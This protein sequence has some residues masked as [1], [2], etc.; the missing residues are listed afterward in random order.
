M[1]S[2]TTILR[3]DEAMV[4][5]GLGAIKGVG[6]SIIKIIIDARQQG[7]FKNLLDFCSR[8][9]RRVINKKSFEALICSG[10]MDDLHDL[11]SEG[12]SEMLAT[13]ESFLLLTEQREL[14]KDQGSLFGEI[15]SEKI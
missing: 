6:E 13:Y 8:V 15:P 10:S 14:A 5:F 4:R 11:G 9:D 12:R 7:L 3:E 1:Y 2:F